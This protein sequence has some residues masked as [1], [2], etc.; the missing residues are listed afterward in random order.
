MSNQII[1]II[2]NDFFKAVEAKNLDAVLGYFHTEAEFLDPHYPSVHMKGHNEI[3]EGL[4]WGFKGV[5]EFNFTEE[6]YFENENKT[7]AAVE[8]ATKIELSA[9]PKLS[10]TQVFIIEVKQ[11][12]IIRCQAY[13]TYG[14]HGM[15]NI[16]LKV[17]RIIQRLKPGGL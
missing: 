11:G 2:I 10:F 1:S 6:N 8:M 15:H 4:T 13:E 3:R 9:G 17:T 7:S 14:P 12:K 16:A 5:K